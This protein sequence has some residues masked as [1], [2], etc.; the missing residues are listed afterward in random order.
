MEEVEGEGAVEEIRG[1]E[2]GEA[3]GGG[4]PGRGVGGGEVRHRGA[5]VLDGRLLPLELPLLLLNP[6]AGVG[7]RPGHSVSG[8]DSRN[9]F[10]L[11]AVGD[12]F[13]LLSVGDVRF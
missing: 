5:Q 6:M 11:W 9:R 12:V 4:G 3:G 8:R 1:A 13:L 10:Y 2:G 7:M